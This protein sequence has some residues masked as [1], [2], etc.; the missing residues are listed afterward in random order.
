MI[1]HVVLAAHMHAERQLLLVT[2]PFTNRPSVIWAVF[3]FLLVLVDTMVPA[4][5]QK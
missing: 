1:G 4:I 5:R 2:K 3:A